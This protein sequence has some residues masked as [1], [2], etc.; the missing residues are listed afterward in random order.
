M[1]KVFTILFD[2]IILIPAIMFTLA[3]SIKELWWQRGI[4]E[5]AEGRY[6]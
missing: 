5:R 4:R 2:I 6:E 1:K 3:I